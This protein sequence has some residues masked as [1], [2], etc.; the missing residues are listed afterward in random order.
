MPNVFFFQ[1][2]LTT[3]SL[4]AI[5]TVIFCGGL[6]NPLIGILKVITSFIKNLFSR[7][8]LA[9][10]FLKFKLTVYIFEQ[11]NIHIYMKYRCVM[12]MK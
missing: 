8:S 1:I 5:V 12:C 6:T 3:T 4:I 10:V 7:S 9:L 11:W 2:F